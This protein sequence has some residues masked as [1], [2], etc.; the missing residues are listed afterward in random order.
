MKKIILIF[1]FLSFFLC[2][3]TRP[4]EYRE[5]EQVIITAAL[6]FDNENGNIALSAETVN[7]SGNEGAY[8]PQVIKGI[9]Q[10][11]SLVL[12]Q[13]SDSLG[14]KMFLGHCT[15]VILGESLTHE[16]IEKIF[17]FLQEEQEISLAVKLITAQN[18]KEAL[19]GKSYF[20]DAVGFDILKL[21]GTK[22][23]I[24]A[25]D[26]Y[27]SLFSVARYKES[28][29]PCFTLPYF[30]TVSGDEE[31][32]LTPDGAGIF[33]GNLYICRLSADE[34]RLFKILSDNFSSGVLL[35]DTNEK[36]IQ[37]QILESN[38][39]KAIDYAD[40]TLILSFDV[41]LTASDKGLSGK[42]ITTFSKTLGE[43]CEE[44][45]KKI[46]TEIKEDIFHIT[47]YIKRYE[48]LIYKKIEKDPLG[49]FLNCEI[50][51]ECKTVIGEGQ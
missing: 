17:S 38:C 2:G 18:A 11:V 27:A 42:D 45:L 1:M 20:D 46:R 28:D 47:D 9:G 37:L 40:K 25:K 31:S 22:G 19:S 23:D 39:K 29:N 24:A 43:E 35:V 30:S 50:T 16:Q 13:I 33:S 44:F 21:L 36:S 5:P 8:K 14:G 34:D 51:V 26:S 49:A 7:T 10:T 41:K 12:Q 6:G 3:C 4:A 15:T 32:R 48:P